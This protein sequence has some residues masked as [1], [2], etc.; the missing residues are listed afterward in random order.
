MRVRLGALQQSVRS[1]GWLGVPRTFSERYDHE[2]VFLLHH[3]LL[4]DSDAGRSVLQMLRYLVVN[5]YGKPREDAE[6]SY[7][8]MCCTAIGKSYVRDISTG[9]AYHSHF[10]LEL[11]ISQ[12]EKCIEDAARRTS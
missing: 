3:D 10:C 4:S 2:A 1:E 11:H 9:L 8:A 7:C 5:T 12:S 6:V